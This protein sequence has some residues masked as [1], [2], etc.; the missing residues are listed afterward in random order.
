MNMKTIGPS[1]LQDGRYLGQ[2]YTKSTM[3]VGQLI[4][5]LEKFDKSYPV[6]TEGCDC[7]G[8]AKSVQLDVSLAGGPVV[9]I[10]R[11]EV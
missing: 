6:M 11:S 7:D 4:E 10:S 2:Y 9:T 1:D 5:A 8:A 3:T